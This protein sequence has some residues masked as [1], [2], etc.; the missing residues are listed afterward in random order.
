M[1]RRELHFQADD[2]HGGP[3]SSPAPSRE[4]IARRAYEISL[5]SDGSTPETNWQRAEAELRNQ[6]GHVP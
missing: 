3:A 6:Q 4:A 2:G 1:H 5:S